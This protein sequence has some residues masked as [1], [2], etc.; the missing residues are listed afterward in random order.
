MDMFAEAARDRKL[1]M[2]EY[3]MRLEKRGR[4]RGKPVNARVVAKGEAAEKELQR[5]GVKLRYHFSKAV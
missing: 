4:G 3:E 1:L 5:L 2:Q